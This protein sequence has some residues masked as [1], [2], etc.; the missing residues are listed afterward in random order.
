MMT[1]PTRDLWIVPKGQRESSQ[2]TNGDNGHLV[3]MSPDHVDHKA[4]SRPGI[5]LFRYV[6]RQRNV[7]EAIVAMNEN[8]RVTGRSGER[9]ARSLGH[10]YVDPE[11][12]G[13]IERI[14]SGRRDRAIA[15]RCRDSEELDL[16]R[17]VEK[18]ERHGVINTWVGIENHL[19]LI[20]IENLTAD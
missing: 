14:A 9:H 4:I 2:R 5:G 17:T 20:H 8:R 19:N 13:E 1:S 12:L 6:L 10:R 7:T 15:M 16:R 11:T 3:C 18:E